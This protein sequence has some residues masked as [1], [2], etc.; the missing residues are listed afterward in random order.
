MAIPRILA[1]VP[2]LAVGLILPSAGAAITKPPASAIGMDHE[3]FTKKVVTIH[4][5]QTVTLVNNSRFIH[6]VGSGKGGHID[7]T[8]PKG[9]PMAGRRLMSTNDTYMT[10][11]WNTP[12]TYYLTCSVHPEMTVK[13]IVTPK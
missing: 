6:I 1:C 10:E 3:G 9:E 5:G 2:L 4:Q 11:T 8:L 12:G 13:I 7:V